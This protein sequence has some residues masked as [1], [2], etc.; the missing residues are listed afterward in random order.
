M[1]D[2]ETTGLGPSDVVVEAALVNAD[3]SVPFESLVRPE[4]PVNRK[5]QAVH[6]LSPKALASAPSWPA[7][8]P[9][10]QRLMRTRTVLAWN[11]A[12]DLRL[13]RQTCDRHNL[14]CQAPDTRCLKAAFNVLHPHVRGTLDA[15]CLTLGLARRPAH[16]A[17][18]DAEVT[19][20]VALAIMEKLSS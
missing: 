15:A 18:R 10:L 16:R 8:W 20:Q 11:A 9:E 12:F 14:S 6:G 1:L 4:R 3:G 7:V 5:A 17:L 19:R 2:T 13:L